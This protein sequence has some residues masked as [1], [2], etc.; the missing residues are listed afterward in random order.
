MP[1]PPGVVLITLVAV[2]ERMPGWVDTA[3]HEYAKRL[4][5]GWRLALRE[6]PA[7][8]RGKGADIAQVLDEEARRCLA[9]VPAD[10]RL[11]VFDRPGRARS[12]QQWA[13]DLDRWAVEGY[14]VSLLIGGPEGVSP[15]LL[16]RA[17]AVWSLSALT[18]A[19]PVVRVVVAEQVYRAWSILNR[20]PYHR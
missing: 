11:V 8:K 9:A 14:G 15:R 4:R 10:D 1:G 6:V 19:H 13:E 12:S 20:L 3:Y 7:V 5:G 16:E 2:G 18:L 17:Q